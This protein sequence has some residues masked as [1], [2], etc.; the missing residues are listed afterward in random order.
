MGW[1]N[2]FADPRP[3][4]WQ[5]IWYYCGPSCGKS[6]NSSNKLRIDT[7]GACPVHSITHRAY[8]PRLAKGSEQIWW[9]GRWGMRLSFCRSAF[10]RFPPKSKKKLQYMQS[11]QLKGI[12]HAL[13]NASPSLSQPTSRMVGALLSRQ[14][15]NLLPRWQP[16][17]P[18]S[19]S[20]AKEKSVVIIC[21][22]S[23]LSFHSPGTPPHEGSL[24]R[25]KQPIF[26]ANYSMELFGFG[27]CHGFFYSHA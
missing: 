3:I 17:L 21:L 11:I 14:Q 22:N 12:N 10:S 2:C 8:G 15:F 20:P 6:V 26:V 1:T 24:V 13:Y 27:G 25:R 23:H 5:W 19:T 18:H 4:V 9:L 7:L 16:L